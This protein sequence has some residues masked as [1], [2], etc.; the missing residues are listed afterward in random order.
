[1]ILGENSEN[2]SLSNLPQYYP[3]F[4]E[5]SAVLTGIDKKNHR[6]IFGI[7]QVSYDLNVKVQLIDTEFGTLDQLLPGMPL[8]F[9]THSTS[10]KNGQI[11]QVWQLPAGTISAH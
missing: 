3:D 10:Y 1:M 11:N 4:F 9:S 7:T 6:L 8:A 5:N 2:V